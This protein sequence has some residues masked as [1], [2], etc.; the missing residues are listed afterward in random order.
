MK[1]ISSYLDSH[2]NEN[3]IIHEVGM[4]LTPDHHS[5]VKGKF[6]YLES[7]IDRQSMRWKKTRFLDKY[8]GLPISEKQELLTGGYAL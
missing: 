2:L 3:F 4:K 8:V 7:K 6:D 5:K 1:R